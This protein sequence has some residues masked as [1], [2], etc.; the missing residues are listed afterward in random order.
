[1]PLKWR[2]GQEKKGTEQ[3]TKERC[4]GPAKPGSSLQHAPSPEGFSANLNLVEKILELS[5]TLLSP[6][7]PLHPLGQ[8]LWRCQGL[9]STLT[10]CTVTS[11]LANA[12]GSATGYEFSAHALTK[13]Y[14]TQFYVLEMSPIN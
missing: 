4:S 12:S 13:S 11:L 5:P 7:C 8:G 1:M 9:S 14:A 10:L 2:L 3:N 6:S